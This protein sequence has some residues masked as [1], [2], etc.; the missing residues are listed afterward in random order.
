MPIGCQALGPRLGREIKRG[1]DQRGQSDLVWGTRSMTLTA[2]IRNQREALI[3]ITRTY[4]L[5]EDG[6]EPDAQEAR[7]EA[8]EIDRSWGSATGYIVKYICKNI[9]G[10]FR[11]NGQQAGDGHGTLSVEE[12]KQLIEQN[13]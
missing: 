1:Q 10:D 3:E 5:L 7:F 9:D 2:L 13:R 12:V 6:D 11:K 8:V 4:A